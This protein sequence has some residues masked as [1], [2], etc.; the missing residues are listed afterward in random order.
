MTLLALHLSAQSPNTASVIVNV[1]DQ[2]DAIVAGA[3][4]SVEN[5]ATGAVCTVTA[6]E[7]GSVTVA[8]LSLNGQYKVTVTKQGF[9]PDD[10]TGLTLRAGE[11]A[12][13][14][15][16]LVVSGGSSEVT[17]F[18]TVKV[19]VQIRRSDAGSTRRRSTKR[20]ISAAKPLRCRFSIPPFARQ[21]HRRPLREP[22]LFRLRR[23]SR[24]NTTLHLTVQER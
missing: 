11:T 18:G 7:D 10:V 16:K 20:L 1:V 5:I 13:V 2:N 4:V 14:R 21:R 6:G 15:V 3:N 17:I 22:N 9:A 19:S 8:G 12:T 23:R 24:R